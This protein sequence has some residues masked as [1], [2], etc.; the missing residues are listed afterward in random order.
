MPLGSYAPEADIAVARTVDRGTCLAFTL[1]DCCGPVKFR[2]SDAYGT[3]EMYVAYGDPLAGKIWVI[4]SYG[5]RPAAIEACPFVV[6][7]GL[8]SKGSGTDENWYYSAVNYTESGS[9][10]A[11][12]VS[13]KF[14]RGGELKG[15]TR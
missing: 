7:S 8:V 11:D 13:V 10:L 12:G 2:V 6:L 4:A 5:V 1:H 15:R 14:F 3:V 9:K